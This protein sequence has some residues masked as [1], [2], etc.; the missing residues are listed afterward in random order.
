MHCGGLIEGSPRLAI[1]LPQA[2]F[3]Q[4]GGVEPCH[5]FLGGRTMVLEELLTGW[6]EWGPSTDVPFVGD[7]HGLA[8][9]RL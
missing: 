6:F 9:D 1:V 4:N 7:Q 2:F 5:V 3:R 8:G